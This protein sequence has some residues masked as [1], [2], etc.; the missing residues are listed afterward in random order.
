MWIYIELVGKYFTKKGTLFKVCMRDDISKYKWMPSI[1][2][3]ECYNVIHFITIFTK[4]HI[5]ST[6]SVDYSLMGA[7]NIFV[8]KKKF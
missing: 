3:G 8:N 2:Y 4:N 5:H 1:W 6:K 7:F